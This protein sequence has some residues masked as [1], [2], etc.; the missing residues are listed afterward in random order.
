MLEFSVTSF[1]QKRVAEK[2]LT[3]AVFAVK[4]KLSKDDSRKEVVTKS[5]IETLREQFLS[6]VTE[7]F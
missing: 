3:A 5:A 1:S 6:H 4:E 7:V 2:G